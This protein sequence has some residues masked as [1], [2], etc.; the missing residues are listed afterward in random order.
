[1]VTDADREFEAIEGTDVV[2]EKKETLAPAGAT[3]AEVDELREQLKG[4]AGLRNDAEIIRKLKEVFGGDAADPKDVMLRKEIR[5]LVPEIDDIDKVKQLLP[6]VVESLEG[7]AEERLQGRI[8]EAQS[9]MQ[10]LMPDIGLDPKDN[11]PT[12][13]FEEVLAHEIRK[14]P[15]LMRLWTRGNVRVA[16]EKA[17]EKV[18]TK[19][20]APIRA[21]SKQGAVRTITESPKA[22]PKGGPPSAGTA[23]PAAGKAATYDPKDTSRANVQKVH[24]AAWDRLQA[25]MNEE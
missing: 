24:D 4:M 1:M 15:D 3:K 9:V 16:V 8:T 2:E 13:Y 6:Y 22:V 7:G 20:V 19:L 5:R 21:K 25:L 18:S 14:N 11:D 23:K 12:G 10:K 17:F